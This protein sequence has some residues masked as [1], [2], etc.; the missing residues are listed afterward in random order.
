MCKVEFSM[1]DHAPF[2]IEEMQASADEACSVLKAIGTPVRLLIL[3]QLL[4]G[5]KSVME[6]AETLSAK[7]SLVSHHLKILKLSD[8][9]ESTR[10]E[11]YVFYSLKETVA[12][13][14]VSVL[15]DE[16]CAKAR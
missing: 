9:V 4:E 3:C 10:A 16:F 5:E 13:R 12:A 15:Y 7:Q 11:K 8:L 14:L 1:L 2:S 6:L